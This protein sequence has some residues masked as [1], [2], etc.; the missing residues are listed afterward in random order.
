MTSHDDRSSASRFYVREGAGAIVRVLSRRSYPVEFMTVM[1]PGLRALAK[2]KRSTAYFQVLLAC[3][4]RLDPIHWRH[5]SAATLAADTGLCQMSVERA[6]KQLE[7][8][9]VV[10][11]QGRSSAKVRRL[12]RS[13]ASNSSADRWNEAQEDA[14]DLPVIDARGR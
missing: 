11:G 12:A 7:A 9:R 6:L 2:N 1:K 3:M 10:I 14:A 4:D 13:L 5:C 8:D